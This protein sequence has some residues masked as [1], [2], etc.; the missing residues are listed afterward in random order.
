MKIVIDIEPRYCENMQSDIKPLYYE[1]ISR[2]KE[3]IRN[4]IPYEEKPQGDLI[5]REALKKTLCEEYEAREHYIG[6]IMLK[7]IDDAPTV[8]PAGR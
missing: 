6:E 7:A 2:I 4:G 3:A 8:I 1:A 5:S